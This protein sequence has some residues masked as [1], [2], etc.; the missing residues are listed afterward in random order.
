[1]FGDDGNLQREHESK[2]LIDSFVTCLFK[3]ADDFGRGVPQ[4]SHWFRGDQRV[5]Q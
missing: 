1:V 2:T 3:V 4:W 5:N